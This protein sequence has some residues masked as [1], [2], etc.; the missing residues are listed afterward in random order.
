MARALYSFVLRLALPLALLRL[1]WRGRR[2]PAYREH[3][4]ERFGRYAER[5]GAGVLWLH[6]VSVGEAR[7][8]APLVRAL[9]GAFP[10]S[11]LLLTCTT[12][13]GR[14]TLAQLYGERV[15]C[16][17]LPYDLPGA[18]ARFVAH[19]RPRI[20]I[21]ME[22]EVWP[23]LL[24]ACRE[25]GTPVVLANARLSRKSARGYARFAWLAR[26][27]FASLAAVCA[28]DRGAARRLAR[29]GARNVV[30]SGNL[31]F[32]VEPDPAKVDEGRAFRTALRGRKVL[33][34]ASTREGEEA[35]LLDALG[36]DDGSLLL[37]VP[38][39]PRRFDE[40]AALLAARG[41]AFAR[42]SL[43]EAPHAAKRVYLGDTMG[44]MA[45]Y[46]STCDV[47]L[48][49]GSFQRLGGQNLIEACALGAPVIVGPHMYNFAEATRQALAA[50]A[51]L[52]ANDAGEAMRQARALLADAGRR[53]QMGAAGVRLCAAHRGAT[54]RH[55]AVVRGL[56]EAAAPAR[57]RARAPG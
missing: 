30:V 44:E 37:V 28:Q 11:D 23:N 24:A 12:A 54:E 6:A 43:G 45:F 49:G 4:G 34:L 22:T 32:D 42:R 36:E 7:A 40:V 33:L 25:R 16:A 47:A 8:A 55:V 52:Q 26:P 39:H 48:I 10:E 31:K 35:L 9:Q 38:R 53:A 46:Y 5:A 15:Q 13:A 2:E 50:G 21:M 3:V 51:A 41:L 19:F 17:F 20:G 29:L 14:T 18:M 1:W 56:L 57:L 27:A